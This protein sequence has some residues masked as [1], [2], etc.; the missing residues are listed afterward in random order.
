MATA[1]VGTKLYWYNGGWIETKIGGDTASSGGAGTTGLYTG[2][3]RTIIP[4]TVTPSSNY[5]ITSVSLKIGLVGGSTNQSVTLYARAYNTLNN[6]KTNLDTGWPTSGQLG[7]QGSVSATD[8]TSSGSMLTVT[9]SGFSITSTTTLYIALHTN[10][11]KDGT[12]GWQIWTIDSGNCDLPTASATE[13][14][15]N[16]TLKYDFQGA[17]ASLDDDIGTSA[18]KTINSRIPEKFGYNFSEWNTKSDGSGT[19][20]NPGSSITLNSSTVTLYAIW[21]QTILADKTG[22]PGWTTLTKKSDVGIWLKFIPS[23]TG[24]YIFESHLISDSEFTDPKI[25]LYGSSESDYLSSHDDII[26]QS[27]FTTHN[28]LNFKL[29]YDLTK[30]Q[31]YYLYIYSWDTSQAGNIQVKG[32]R[33]YTLTIE[34]QGGSY[35]QN[36]DGLQLNQTVTS[37]RTQY[38][39]TADSYGVIATN[40]TYGIFNKTDKGY[41]KGY[42]INQ[43]IREGYTFNGWNLKNASGST[44]S[45]TNY[46]FG[47]GGTNTDLTNQS[48]WGV[49]TFASSTQTS[50][51]TATAKWVQN[52]YTVETITNTGIASISGGGTYSSGATVTLA[53]T[54]QNGY[55]FAYWRDE[56]DNRYDSNPLTITNLTKNKSFQAFGNLLTYSI[57][58]NSNGGSG[59]MEPDEKDYGES[60]ALPSNTFTPPTTKKTTFSIKC[61]HNDGSNSY[62][63][64]IGS[65]TTSY[66]F[67]QWRLNSSAGTPYAVGANY[68]TNAN[69][70]FYADWKSTDS[71]SSVTLPTLTSRAN[72]TA[73]GYTVNYDPNEGEEMALQSQTAI[74]TISYTFEGWGASG[75]DTSV[76]YYGGQSYP[77][78]DSINLYAIWSSNTS[79]GGFNLPAEDDV[80][81]TGYTLL[82]W[83]KTK[84]SSFATYTPGQFYTPTSN[85]E[86]LYAIWSQNLFTITLDHQG[87]TAS[88][89]FIQWQYNT[90]KWFNPSS[91]VQINY[92]TP[93]TKTG[94]IF[95]GYYYGNTQL[96]DKDGNLSTNINWTTENTTITANWSPIT[97]TVHYD[98]APYTSILD[99]TKMISQ[100]TYDQ[101]KN[102]NT[103]VLE[104]KYTV[105]YD[106][107]EGRCLTTSSTISYSLLGWDRT[108][109]TSNNSTPEFSNG[110]E[111]INLTTVN[112]AMINLY[113]QW[114]SISTVLPTP[115]REGYNFLGW[116]TAKTGGSK[117]GSAGADYTPNANITLYAHW[118][119]ITYSVTYDLNGGDENDAFQDQT[120]LTSYTI[121]NDIPT[122]TNNDFD[123]WI[124]KETGD[125]YSPGDTIILTQNITLQAVWLGYYTITILPSEGIGS[126]EFISGTS[127]VVAGSTVQIKATVQNKGYYFQQ[128]IDDNGNQ[129]STNATITI[130]N[131][132]Q[133]YIIKPIAQ[134]NYGLLLLLNKGQANFGVNGSTGSFYSIALYYNRFWYQT[135]ANAEVPNSSQ[136]ITQLTPPVRYG[137]KFTGYYLDDGTQVMDENGVL[138][139]NHTCITNL[140]YADAHWEPLG[141]V[142]I[143]VDNEWK[144]AIPYI[145]DGT[146]W[147]QAIAHVYEKKTP[148]SSEYEWKVSI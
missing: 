109:G 33:G 44:V 89:K 106:P 4:V 138:T 132:N 83:S 45:V 10:P 147:R 94:Y 22:S 14:V 20:Y 115:S 71:Y 95:Q 52:T 111:V 87:G 6:A 16:Y 121:P 64:D 43:P 24:T 63:S 25:Q 21:A 133:N 98:N 30:N 130:N 110:Q 60:F 7:N 73:N 100:H 57:N 51:L 139:T 93:P 84:T 35:L 107:N 41:S 70:I 9:M 76:D 40:K 39:S 124:I 8:V 47:V 99:T 13:S 50:N 19:S 80:Y 68:T 137:Y 79:K 48:S 2:A 86:T 113:P 122:K 75:S 114:S 69:A 104:R 131:I 125:E 143:R 82:G 49:A 12:T 101:P 108:E 90:G 38:F 55:S 67:K 61:Y 141:L 72:E 92:I 117:V 85:N 127:T 145:Y 58:Y 1:S 36:D 42:Y 142:H 27:D 77:F 46:G 144:Y 102:L 135:S 59:T 112:G 81:R 105:T 66:S 78:T 116:Y 129:L 118:K 29:I 18:T 123:C 32:G 5:K 148:D 128:W 54:L 3:K 53:A 56:N 15:N 23:Q 97:Y 37:N 11:D 28:N 126:V 74:D 17:D 120:N 119:Q 146:E 136:A 34:P 103:G 62:N 91:G 88:I 65:K 140:E 96:I 26:Y 134:P 31:T